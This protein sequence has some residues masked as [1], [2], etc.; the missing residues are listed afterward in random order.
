[1]EEGSEEPCSDEKLSKYR[2]WL[3]AAAAYNLAWAASM[4]SF[5][6]STS[7]RSES[8]RRITPAYGRSSACSS[9]STRPY[10]W[11]ARQPA[12]HRHLVPDRSVRQAV[13]ADRFRLG[14][15]E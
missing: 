14:S 11:A 9:S 3:Y 6:R 15:R 1:M 12:R 2:P 10:W 7:K 13:Q 5:P 8:R 4:S